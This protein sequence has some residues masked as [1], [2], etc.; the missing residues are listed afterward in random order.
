[1]LFLLGFNN[2]TV[3]A[4]IDDQSPLSTVLS[5]DANKNGVDRTVPNGLTDITQWFNIADVKNNNAVI[6]PANTGTNKGSSDV[7]KLTEFGSTQKSGAIWSKRS[8]SDAKN[9]N[10]IDINKQQTMSMWMFFGGAYTT[11]GADT[12]DGMALVLQNVSDNAFTQISG[13]KSAGESL[14]VWGSPV[15]PVDIQP[16]IMAQRAIQ[17]SWA[18]EFDTYMNADDSYNSNFDANETSLNH[19]ASNYPALAS[20]YLANNKGLILNHENSITSM[21]T[22]GKS[23]NFLTDDRWHHITLTWVPAASGSTKAKMILNY[24]DKNLDGTPKIDKNTGK[25]NTKEME[26]DTSNFNLKDSSKLYWGFTGSTGDSSE[27][28][29]IIFESIPSIAEAD[30][31]ASIIDETSG[32]RELI[33]P[34]TDNPNANVVHNNDKL[35]VNYNLSYDS[36]S[37]PWQDI[38]AKIKLPENIDYQSALIT[39]TDD[40]GNKSTENI[41]E[42]SGMTDNEITHK[43][44]KELYY[45]SNNQN[46]NIKSAKISFEG[47]ANSNTK[48]DTNV[49][50]EHASFDGS[51]LQK[52]VMTQAFVIK[53]PQGITLAKTGSDVS[54]N[55]GATADLTGK[56]S[57][58]DSST[59]DPTNLSVYAKVNNGSSTIVQN[60][61]ANPFTLSISSIKGANGS[62]NDLNEGVNT[63]MLYVMDNTTY[64]VSNEITYTI[65]VLG[66]LKVDAHDSSFQTI[67]SM[68]NKQ[69]I[70]REDNWSVDVIDSRQKGS[71]WYLSASATPLKD[72][73]KEWQGGMVY[74]DSNGNEA[75]LT[76]EQVLVGKGVKSKDGEE[77]TDIDQTWTKDS[78]ILLKQTDFE[79]A[80]HYSSTIT[81]TAKDSL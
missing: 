58:S 39:Y 15:D 49:A 29:L 79:N 47:S 62:G 75:N 77:T 14:G 16:E 44:A 25:I 1:M 11:G 19:I 9:Q 64:E 70:K 20:T 22:T 81:W 63:V 55:T 36:G 2:Y 43:L 6:L 3:K 18:L 71:N 40:N 21:S 54:I 80:G 65:T 67:Q 31:K 59:V 72:G 48:T 30:A 5:N 60:L 13:D 28:N 37:Q 52:D 61:S 33:E 73:T 42:F 27:N 24:D 32:N 74:V 50:S 51:N 68:E 57:Y 26:V 66:S 56:I 78:G 10:Y 45:D 7:I 46:G 35:S 34:T 38:E 23:K 17:N 4:A 69:M 41:D 53:Q 8:Q 12:G 76:N